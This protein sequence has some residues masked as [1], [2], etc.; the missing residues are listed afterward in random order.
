V[1]SP[2]NFWVAKT[3]LVLLT[4]FEHFLFL[5]QEYHIHQKCPDFKHSTATLGFQSA[6]KIECRV[7]G[8]FENLLSSVA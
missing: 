4:Y 5:K 7:F 2:S 6:E 8:G 3:Q 1:D